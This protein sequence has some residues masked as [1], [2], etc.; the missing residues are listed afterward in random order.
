MLLADRMGGA[1]LPLHGQHWPWH[2]GTVKNVAASFVVEEE[3]FGK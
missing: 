2:H 3:L 1:S